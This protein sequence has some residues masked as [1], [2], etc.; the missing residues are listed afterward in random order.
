MRCLQAD[1]FRFSSSSHESKPYLGT[2]VV[3]VGQHTYSC[4]LKQCLSAHGRG[5]RISVT[6][7]EELAYDLGTYQRRTYFLRIRADPDFENVSDFAVTIYFKNPTKKKRIQIA[8]VDTA[9]DYTHF[10]TLYRQDEP[11][12]P[13]DWGLWETVE[14]FE[15]EWRT[16][17]ESH[18]QNVE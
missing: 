6:M 3:V 14:R 12:E 13:V 18:E 10:D 11:T 9:H 1:R 7:T 15:S 2:Y 17:A 8:R 5:P 4:R 16:W